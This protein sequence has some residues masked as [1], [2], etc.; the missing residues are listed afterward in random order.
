[1]LKGSDA[2]ADLPLKDS[3]PKLCTVGAGADDGKLLLRRGEELADEG[4]DV[5]RRRHDCSG[6]VG[7]VFGERWLS[8]R[9]ERG[10]CDENENEGREREKERTRP[11]TESVRRK[12]LKR[13]PLL[14]SF[15]LTFIH[16]SL[17]PSSHS[18]LVKVLL[19]TT[20]NHSFPVPM[21][22]ANNTSGKSHARGKGVH[23]KECIPLQLPLTVGH[24]FHLPPLRCHPSGRCILCKPRP[25]Y[26]ALCPR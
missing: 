4:G 9:K 10:G 26:P 6:K 1:M 16:S 11:R 24:L 25:R 5:G 19:I 2:V 17:H 23:S 12:R 14:A 3:V 15:I 8:W 7:G 20:S 18:L 13:T 22:S 21:M